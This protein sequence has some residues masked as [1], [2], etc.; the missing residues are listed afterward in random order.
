M[1]I[2]DKCYRSD[3]GYFSEL[4]SS[5]DHYYVMPELRGKPGPRMQY[6]DKEVIVWSINSYLG[7]HQN[8]DYIQAAR[9]ALEQYGAEAPMGS[10]L[11]SGNSGIHLALEKDLSAF[12]QQ[13]S[14]NLFANGYLAVVGIIAAIVGP[15]DM[16]VAD[17]ECHAC[18]IDGMR[19]AAQP[20][21]Y[22]I[23]KHNDM[24]DLEAVLTSVR[25][26]HQ[27]GILILSEGLFGMTGE[28]AKLD[29]I[30][31]LKERFHARLMVDDAHGFGS[32]GE[33]GR[34]AG[35]VHQVMD[36][37]DLYFSTF[38]KSFAGIGGFVTGPEA[39]IQYLRFNARTNIFTKSLPMIYASTAMAVLQYIK[40][41]GKELL[42]KLHANA[43]RLREGLLELGYDLGKSNAQITPVYMPND[44]AMDLQIVRRLREEFH[45]F[46]SLVAYPVVPQNTMLIRLVPTALHS[47]EDVDKTLAAF[48]A[49]KKDIR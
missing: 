1:D 26:T 47:F 13:E 2:F 32:I 8:P 45:I 36:K 21:K 41:D 9:S 14:A 29:Q 12:C 35:E 25:K 18:L 40:S 22:R 16:V 10:R 23:Y 27:G 49:V 44:M 15:E 20:G 42:E 11:M 24:N 38:A 4:R 3:T 5:D 28:V 30:C 34:G 33:S 31:E 46:V 6:G 39:V 19:L 7:M 43:R 48:E 17:R 37:I